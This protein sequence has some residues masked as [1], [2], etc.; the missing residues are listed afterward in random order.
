MAARLQGY[1]SI[2]VIHTR[3]VT[4]SVGDRWLVE[5]LL[6]VKSTDRRKKDFR[7]HWLFP[8]WEWELDRQDRQVELRFK[9]PLGWVTIKVASN[10]E[11]IKMTL[12]RAG[13]R[14]CGEGMVSPIMGWYSPSY[15]Q[16]EPAHS[17][18]VNVSGVGSVKFTTEF[19]FP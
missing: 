5:D 14:I 4:Q 17:F 8:D 9:S 7:L 11:F 13:E 10:L 3:T 1:K 18:A 15:G 12:A 19:I 6:D 2:G 16:K